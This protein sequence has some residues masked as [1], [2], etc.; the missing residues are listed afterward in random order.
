MK[1]HGYD[2]QYI[3]K[4][5]PVLVNSSVFPVVYSN[6]YMANARPY[7]AT[8]NDTSIV[9]HTFLWGKNIHCPEGWHEYT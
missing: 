6:V 8:C 4:A 3:Y 7:T 2:M 5:I 1:L 9:T